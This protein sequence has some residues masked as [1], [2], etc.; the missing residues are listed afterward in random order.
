MTEGGLSSDAGQ[1]IRMGPWFWAIIVLVAGGGP[2][3]MEMR[4]TSS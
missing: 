4:F 3:H 1:I 2:R